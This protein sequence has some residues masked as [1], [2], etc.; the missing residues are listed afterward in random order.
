M[1]ELP[2][3]PI[4]GDGIVLRPFRDTDIHDIVTA[5]NDPESRQ[6]LQLLPDPY[7]A[8][9]ATRWA[10]GQVPAAWSAGTGHHLAVADPSTDRLL[11]AVGLHPI[12]L[13]GHATSIGYWVAPWSRRQGV[14]TRATRALTAWAYTHGFGRVELTTD[15]GNVGSLRVAWAAGFTHEGIRRAVGATREGTWRDL[16]VWSRLVDDSG[17]PARRLLPDVAD[18]QLSDGV[19]TL[20]PLRVSDAGDLYTLISL[21]EVIATTVSD[22][23][24][25]PESARNRCVRNA[26]MWLIGTRA[27]FVICDAA[28]GAFAGT[29]GLFT[30]PPTGQAMVGYSV[31]REWRGRSFA[32]RATRLL[33]DW[34]IDHAGIARVIAG[35]APDNLGSQRSL[36]RAG[37]VREGYERSRLPGR[38][39]GPRIDDVVFAL[40]PS[41]R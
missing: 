32:A 19:V 40:L 1:A 22:T 4:A 11:G 9:D 15:I 10:L 17:E 20:R 31:T 27:D 36:E 34:A 33:A 6:F 29:I 21:P 26:Y 41:D 16:V 24:P 25:T 18:G 13:G 5:V 2:S 8:D 12:R 39:G 14:A 38:D 30:E 35:T 28:T 37:F 3:D 23:L 7:T